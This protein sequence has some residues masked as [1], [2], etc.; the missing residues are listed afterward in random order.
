MIKFKLV[1]LAIYRGV[2]GNHVMIWGLNK[3]WLISWKIMSN[4]KNHWE[5]H[6]CSFC[7]GVSGNHVK[8]ELC[9]FCRICRWFPW[10]FFLR[11]KLRWDMANKRI[12]RKVHFRPFFWDSSFSTFMW[13]LML[14]AFAKLTHVQCEV[15]VVL[16]SS[17]NQNLAQGS[18]IMIFKECSKPKRTLTLTASRLCWRLSYHPSCSK[19]IALAYSTSPSANHCS[20]ELWIVP[21]P[22]QAAGKS[23]DNFVA[24]HQDRSRNALQ[25]S[26]EAAYGAFLEELRAD[27]VQFQSELILPLGLKG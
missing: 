1:R 9:F 7:R 12:K 8:L 5:A 21:V 17:S 26:M 19:Y 16:Y 2:S 18:W 6:I 3:G 20:K 22:T 10:C 13:N 4:S 15:D 25:K 14:M 23:M 11:K 24:E 27:Q